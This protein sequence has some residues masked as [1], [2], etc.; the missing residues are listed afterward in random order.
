M[1]EAISHR[2]FD[3]GL[4]RELFLSKL[5]QSMQA[6]LA[7]FQGANDGLPASADRISEISRKPVLDICTLNAEPSTSNS[8]IIELCNTLRQSLSLESSRTS[9][10]PRRNSSRDSTVRNCP[11]SK[12]R[13]SSNPHWYWYHST[14]DQAA[15]RCG[16]PCSF[17]NDLRQS[18]N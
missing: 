8:E 6:V 11:G 12:P 7:T 10:K 17:S 15:V 1:W 18:G 5:L 3:K 4:F 14:Y 9:S 16:K 13:P 2:N